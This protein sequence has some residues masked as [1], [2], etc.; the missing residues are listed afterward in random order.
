MNFLFSMLLSALFYTDPSFVSLLL[1]S[2]LGKIPI[3]RISG[4]VI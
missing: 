3:D 4:F 2:K 1:N